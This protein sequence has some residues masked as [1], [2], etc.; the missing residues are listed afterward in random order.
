MELAFTG[1]RSP[2][3]T[4]AG[5]N[6]AFFFFVADPEPDRLDERAARAELIETIIRA[7]RHPQVPAGI[8]GHTDRNRE[9]PRSGASRPELE[10]IDSFAERFGDS[11]RPALRVTF[12]RRRKE[13]GFAA[14]DVP[15]RTDRRGLLRV[16]VIAPRPLVPRGVDFRDA[17]AIGIVFKGPCPFQRV[18]FAR[19]IAIRVVFVARLL[20]FAAR[21]R[22]FDHFRI[23]VAFPFD[24]R[25]LPT[26]SRH[27]FHIVLRIIRPFRFVAV[28]VLFADAVARAVVAVFGRMFVW[29]SD[30]YKIVEAVIFIGRRGRDRCSY[31]ARD[32]L[33]LSSTVEMLHSFRAV[34]F[35]D[36]SF[37][38]PIIPFSRPA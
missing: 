36:I 38:P 25:R 35:C 22:A 6:L 1:A 30:S 13:R 26:R 3:V 28:S 33:Y 34:R 11:H 20:R 31:R 10:V 2:R 32:L 21:R 27:R 5:T 8:E 12:D 14:A 16:F 23:A 29:V 15:P 19:Q 18:G 17:I 4:T 24:R 7:I 9:L 37:K